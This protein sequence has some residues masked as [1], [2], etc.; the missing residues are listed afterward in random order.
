MF[1]KPLIP[2]ALLWP[3]G[4]QSVSVW[5]YGA[6]SWMFC[7]HFSALDT[8]LGQ[9]ELARDEELIFNPLHYP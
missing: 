1:S 3:L 4:D 5:D 8:G 9:M 2:A 6:P 7:S